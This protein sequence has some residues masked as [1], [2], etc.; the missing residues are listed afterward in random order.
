MKLQYFIFGLLI[1]V[2]FSC[3]GGRDNSASRLDNMLGGISGSYQEID[4]HDFWIDGYQ[5]IDSSS[6]YLIFPLW[7]G[8]V[9]QQNRGMKSLRKWDTPQ[10]LYWNLLFYN[11]LTQEKHLL[12]QEKAIVLSFSPFKIDSPRV[13]ADQLIFYKIIRKDFNGD[14][15]L[16]LKDPV[17]LYVSDKDGRNFRTLT[18][19]NRDLSG[20]KLYRNSPIL[21]AE[22]R[23]DTDNDSLFSSKDPLRFIRVD[24]SDGNPGKPAFDP[25][26]LDQL[27][28]EMKKLFP[29]KLEDE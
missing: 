13:A 24:L 17:Q 19:E 20:W 3:G 12:F 25:G 27:E 29:P 22:V 7:L 5:E 26:Y 15:E 1:P 9:G 10:N 21:L 4:G 11:P 28:K 23:E 2:L 6:D 16:D 8:T 18:P 14:G